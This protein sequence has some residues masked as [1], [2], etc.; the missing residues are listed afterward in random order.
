[1]IIL[2]GCQ[3]ALLELQVFFINLDVFVWQ[4]LDTNRTDLIHLC[5]T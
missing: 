2:G 1:M 3:A 5:K 4:N